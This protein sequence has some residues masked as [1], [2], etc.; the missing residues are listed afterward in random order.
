MQYNN[1][2]FANVGIWTKEEDTQL[3]NIVK[4]YGAHNWNE[5]SN[6]VQGR[7]AKQ[8]RERWH[9]HLDTELK[10]GEWTPAEDSIILNSQ[11]QIGNQWASITKNLIGRRDNDVKNRFHQLQRAIK[12]ASPAKGAKRKIDYQQVT[13]EN[14]KALQ[15]QRAI[16]EK[17]VKSVSSFPIKTQKFSLF[18]TPNTMITEMHSDCNT[19]ITEDLYTTVHSNPCSNVFSLSVSSL[20]SKQYDQQN[21]T[22]QNKDFNN[23]N[24]ACDSDYHAKPL[25]NAPLQFLE[26]D[27]YNNTTTTSIEFQQ[28]QQQQQ[29]APLQY[30]FPSVSSKTFY[31]YESSSTATSLLAAPILT[32]RHTYT[33]SGLLLLPQRSAPTGQQQQS[34]PVHT[35]YFPLYST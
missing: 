19:E 27:Q 14:L 17:Q 18:S 29:K 4:Q 2:I 26:H 13:I 24:T 9:N 5:I 7:N 8:C 25:S 15:L 31:S 22:V 28:Q 16:E 20:C 11:Q 1:K 30:H 12:K 23:S 6:R 21:T 10:K 35:A 3:T 33:P 34:E 32:S